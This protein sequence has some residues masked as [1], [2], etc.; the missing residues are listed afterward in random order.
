MFH[1]NCIRI[2]KKNI[3]KTITVLTVMVL[4]FGCKK[5][6]DIN[7]SPNNPSIS[8]ATPEVLFPSGVGSSAGRIGGELNILGGI[9][10]ELYTQNTLANQYLNF[11]DYNLTKNDFK[12][13]YAELYAGALEDYQT[14][15][16]NAKAKGQFNFVLMSTAMKAYTMEALDDLYDE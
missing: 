5:I 10:A 12:D 2:M 14:S 8:A 1:F 3:L 6:T 16:I 13:D 11:D 4:S 9:W 7:V 15:I